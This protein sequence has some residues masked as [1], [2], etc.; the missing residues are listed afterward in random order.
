MGEMVRGISK[1]SSTQDPIIFSMS[2]ENDA[3]RLLEHLDTERIFVNGRVKR[4]IKES[5]APILPPQKKVFYGE[6]RPCDLGF[7]EDPLLKEFLESKRLGNFNRR[8]FEFLEGI[9]VPFTLVQK[10]GGTMHIGVQ[11]I[12]I[13][14]GEYG[15]LNIFQ[16]NG[17]PKSRFLITVPINEA[18]LPH[19]RIPRSFPFLLPFI[20]PPESVIKCLGS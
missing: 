7:S 17:L 1:I 5:N 18:S 6:V 20:E 8:P 13:S 15:L 3:E 16:L 4:I 12:K 2:I 14:E 9:N 10:P 11:P 19:H